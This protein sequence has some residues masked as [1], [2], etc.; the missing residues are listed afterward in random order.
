[1]T[2]K[3]I[4]KISI[5][6]II[7]FTLPSLILY[8]FVYFKYNEELP[9]GLQG[10]EADALAYKMLNALDYEAF[11]NTDYIE[12]T[13]KKR[14]HYKWYKNENNCD[15]LWKDYKVNINLK[16]PSLNKAYVHGFIIEG[17]VGE[18]LIE[19][20]VKYFKNDS[21]WLVAPYNVFDESAERRLVKNDGLLVTYKDENTTTQNSY[22]WLLD[23]EGKPNA[24]K[25]WT[26]LLPINGLEASWNDW[27]ITESGAQLPTTHR[28]IFGNLGIQNLK[29]R[30]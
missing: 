15:V 28:F 6:V 24:V 10:D 25:M 4:I 26:S 23:K 14:R 29:T 18:E 12:W 13:F 7:F 30:L 5:G 9:T 27:T 3:K 2:F 11:E 1:M 21:F 16:D 17:E 8:G 19:K 22:L 20:A